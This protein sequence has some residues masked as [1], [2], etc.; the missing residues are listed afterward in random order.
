MHDFSGEKAKVTDL[1]N[2]LGRKVC[3]QK[4]EKQERCPHVHRGFGVAG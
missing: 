4:K 1:D 3:K 2:E